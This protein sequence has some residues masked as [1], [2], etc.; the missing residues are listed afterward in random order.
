MNK[1]AIKTMKNDDAPRAALGDFLIGVV[2]EAIEL[3][4]QCRWDSLSYLLRLV[5]ME[6]LNCD[7]ACATSGEGGKGRRDS[8]KACALQ[9]PGA[10][11]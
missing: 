5:L 1:R 7:P 6:A 10:P 2:P 8:A 3:S 11:G 4:E 9:N